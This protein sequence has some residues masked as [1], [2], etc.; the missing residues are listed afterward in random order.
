MEF[1][2]NDQK[3]EELNIDQ[4]TIGELKNVIVS[5]MKIIDKFY[6]SKNKQEE[7]QQHERSFAVYQTADL[8][9]AY[10]VLSAVQSNIGQFKSRS[11]SPQP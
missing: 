5:L 7:E 4:F 8:Q 10:N 1:F 11:K 3:T 9:Q 6:S 2:L